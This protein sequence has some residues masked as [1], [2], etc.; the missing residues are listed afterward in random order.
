M[1]DFKN[2]RIP[3]ILQV[4]YPLLPVFAKHVWNHEAGPKTVFFWAP[5]IKWGLVIA[6]ITDLKRPAE[7]LSLYQNMALFA[8]GA[9]W[10]RYSFA[11]RP[12]NYNLASV[13]VFLCTV[14]LCQIMRKLRFDV[15]FSIFMQI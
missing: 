10:T 15:R 14:G 8:T 4:I 6:G 11:I 12:I 3:L 2:H 7:K 13:N 5:A 1:S 9:I